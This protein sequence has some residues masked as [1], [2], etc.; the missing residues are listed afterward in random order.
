MM[1]SLSYA[2]QDSKTFADDPAVI[3]FSRD[4]EQRHGFNAN[5][6]LGY[7]S[8]VSLNQRVLDLMKSFTSPR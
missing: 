7:F 5:D 6:L 4:M 3:E 8:R 1:T 2:A